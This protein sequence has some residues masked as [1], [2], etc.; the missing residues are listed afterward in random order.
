MT[1]SKKVDVSA[2]EESMDEVVETLELAEQA[3]EFV[4]AHSDDP[5]D[6]ARAAA[7]QRQAGAMLEA[8]QD[9]ESERAPMPAQSNAAKSRTVH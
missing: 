5:A 1:D 2:L 4:Q 9:D 7:V 8:A 3:A 6:R